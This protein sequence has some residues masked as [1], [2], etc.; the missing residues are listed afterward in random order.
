MGGNENVMDNEIVMDEI[1]EYIIRLTN[2]HLAIE[3]AW[4]H[5]S[6]PQKN[7]VKGIWMGFT[8][9]RQIGGIDYEFSMEDLDEVP[10]PLVRQPA[11]NPSLLDIHR[12]QR[13]LLDRAYLYLVGENE[14][15]AQMDNQGGEDD[16][17]DTEGEDDGDDN[18]D[19][20]E[21]GG[22]TKKRKSKRRKSKHRKSKKRKSKKRKS[23]RRK[24]KTKRR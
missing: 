7:E 11:G 4:N 14:Q 10:P 12:R 19:Y 8:L 17:M 1:D 24:S 2:E 21:G 16:N 22:K 23:K 6:D 20:M 15:Q 5:L 13:Q 9:N 3:N 18:G